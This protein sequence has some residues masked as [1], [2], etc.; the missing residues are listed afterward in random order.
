[1]INVR[2]LIEGIPGRNAFSV[3]LPLNS[4]IGDLLDRMEHIESDLLSR[5]KDPVSGEM[6]YFLVAVNGKM[7]CF[8]DAIRVMLKDGDEVLFVSPLVGG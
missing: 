8:P 3:T 7:V 1:M 2:V 5:I 6:Q 4:N